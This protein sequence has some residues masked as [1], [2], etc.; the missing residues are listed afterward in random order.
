MARIYL[1]EFA[2]EVRQALA[3]FGRGERVELAETSWTP[4]DSQVPDFSPPTPE[5]HPMWREAVRQ[6]LLRAM[7][8]GPYLE[9]VLDHEIGQSIPAPR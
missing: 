4:K 9:A 6:Q 5:S 7:P 2:Q 3:R 8:P 1:T